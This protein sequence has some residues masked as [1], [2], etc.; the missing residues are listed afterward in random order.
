[1][2]LLPRPTLRTCSDAAAASSTTP[3][4]PAAEETLDAAISEGSLHELPDGSGAS[5]CGD[6]FLL[7][8]ALAHFSEISE[9]MG[10]EA[11]PRAY[12]A[13][14]AQQAGVYRAVREAMDVPT[15]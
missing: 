15:E 10:F 7:R 5:A 14:T 9:A 12:V 13:H 6:H 4:D 8:A 1:M 11:S 3:R 2:A